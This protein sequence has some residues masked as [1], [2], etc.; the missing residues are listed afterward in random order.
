M[1]GTEFYICGIKP[2]N[3]KIKDAR[4]NKPICFMDK[5]KFKQ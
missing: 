5:N 3:Y 1:S 2:E 4:A